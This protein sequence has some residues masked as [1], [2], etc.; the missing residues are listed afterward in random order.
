MV[1]VDFILPGMVRLMAEIGGHGFEANLGY[2][3]RLCVKKK[4]ET[5]S[6]PPNCT[7]LYASIREHGIL[8]LSMAAASRL[9]SSQHAE[10]H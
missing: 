6:H 7:L 1:R 10:E 4:K 9:V 8:M 2:I 3:V 5:T